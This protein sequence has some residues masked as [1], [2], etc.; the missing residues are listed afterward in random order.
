MFRSARVKLTVYYLLIIMFISGLF[1][2]A[3]YRVVTSEL[4]TRFSTI[5]RRIEFEQRGFGL[6]PA[7]RAFLAGHLEGA[8]RRVLAIL[9]L[10]N[11]V[12]LVFSGVA[13]YFL[14]GKTL[15][16]IEEALEEQKRFVAD[17]SHEL[18][19]PLT[20]LKTSIEVALR[21]KK[22]TTKE[23]KETLQ[24][25]LEEADNLGILASDLLD[26]T[27][28][29]K[30]ST[31]LTFKQVDAGRLLEDVS[32]KVQPLA[33]DK[34]I[35]LEVNSA[36]AI[37]KADETSLNKVITILLDNAI[38]Y[39]P[40]KGKVTATAKVD[41]RHFFLEV[42]D[43]GI[44]IRQSDIPHIFDRFY[45]VDQSRSKMEVPGFGLGLS[46][47]KEIVDLHKG[48]IEVASAFGKGST[49]TVKLPLKHS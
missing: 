2:F 47:A 37:L 30:A 21:D 9:L 13:G 14:A 45:R 44:G 39:T 23:A 5:E 15:R 11:G 49:F 10:A 28:Y 12:I 34:D 41:R 38:K 4:E 46:M 7:Q 29:Q 36:K 40:K 32:K 17:A 19:T 42:K 27:R 26:L 35:N 25:S 33:K 20:S 24:S 22:M 3:I 16:P 1:S 48:S 6:P 31:D 18:R 8:K 43:T